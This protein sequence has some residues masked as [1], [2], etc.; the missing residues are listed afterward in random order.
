MSMLPTP[1]MACKRCLTTSLAMAVSSRLQAINGVGSI[2]IVGGQEREFH[3]WIDPQRL[4]SFGLAPGDVAQALAS[5]NVEIP[6]GRLDSGPTELS[7]KTRG[8]VHTA[9]EL[10]NIIITAA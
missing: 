9:E 4:D 10:G 2:D 7:I 8:Q 5:Q 3:V 6:G 1:L